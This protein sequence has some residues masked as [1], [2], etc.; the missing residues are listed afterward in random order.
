[1][2]EDTQIA[3]KGITGFILKN[4]NVSYGL[5]V[6]IKYIGFA[7]ILGG[8]YWWRADVH[9]D[10]GVKDCEE[11]QQTADEKVQDTAELFSNTLDTIDLSIDNQKDETEQDYEQEIEKIDA[12]YFVSLGRAEGRAL[13]RAQALATFKANNTDCLPVVYD[14]DSVMRQRARSLQQDVFGSSDGNDEAGSTGE[15]SGLAGAPP[16]SYAPQD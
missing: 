6:A 11:A 8:L 1:M 15:V 16:K 2:T 5:A 9:Y 12:E 4:A 14:F 7:S 3:V 13:G 10:N